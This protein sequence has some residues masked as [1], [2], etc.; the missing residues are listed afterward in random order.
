MHAGAVTPRAGADGV[1]QAWFVIGELRWHAIC[2]RAIEEPLKLAPDLYEITVFGAERIPTTTAF[3]FHLCWQAISASPTSCSTTAPGMRTTASACTWEGESRGSIES[4]GK[5]LRKTGL[6]EC[7]DRL[8]LATGSD[9]VILPVPGKDLPGVLTYRD[10]RDTEAMIDAARSHRRSEGP[11]LSSRKT[12][13]R[14]DRR[15]L[16]ARASRAT[17][18]AATSARCCLPISRSPASTCFSDSR[19]GRGGP[20]LGSRGN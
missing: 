14:A 17:A 20:A 7:Y 11:A 15:A 10:I 2:D 5:S 8:L 9:P 19:C 6:E 16:G 13:L 1:H 3:G 4:K 18:S 12:D